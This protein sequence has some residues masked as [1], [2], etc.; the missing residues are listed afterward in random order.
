M[1]RFSDY[2][3]RKEREHGTRWDTSG[4]DT[5]FVPYFNSGE[6]IRVRTWGE[7]ITGTVGVTTGW[8]PAFLLMR[9]SNSIGSPVVLGPDDEILAVQRGGKYRPVVCVGW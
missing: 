7:E 5:R 2:I 8:R 4:L 9:R 3:A 1:T 6:R